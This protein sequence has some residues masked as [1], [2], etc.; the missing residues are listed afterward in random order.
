MTV[1]PDAV[2]DFLDRFDDRAPEI[3]AFPGCQRLALWRDADAPAVFTTHSH[4][5]DS[6]ALERYRDSELFADAWTAV[7]PL[8]SDRAE[9]HS[10]H[11]VRPAAELD[12]EAGRPPRRT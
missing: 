1:R 10:Y 11:V 3:R 7:K 9:A 8:F 6:A 4:W 5:D 2:D 12:R